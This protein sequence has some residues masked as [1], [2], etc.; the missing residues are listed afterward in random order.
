MGGEDAAA[1]TRLT[2]RWVIRE[3]GEEVD[4]AASTAQLRALVSEEL[5]RQGERGALDLAIYF[6]PRD[7]SAMLVTAEG[8][9]ERMHFDP[10]TVALRLFR[11]GRW[12]VPVA[13]ATAGAGEDGDGEA[14]DAR[15]PAGGESVPD[16]D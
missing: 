12:L 14:R 5:T 13:R 16:A 3:T 11:S 8:E 9:S 15:T 4:L 10:R 2:V 6:D 7:L 1:A